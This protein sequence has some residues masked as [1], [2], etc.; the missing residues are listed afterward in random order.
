[1]ILT[2]LLACATDPQAAVCGAYEA[3]PA[4]PLILPFDWN[5]FS[6]P[7]APEGGGFVDA[8]LANAAWRAESDEGMQV[9]SYDASG[10]MIRSV[11]QWEGTDEDGQAHEQTSSNT[12]VWDATGC[13]S[14]L[15]STDAAGLESITR[16][17]CDQH[18][19]VDRMMYEDGSETE[20]VNSYNGVALATSTIGTTVYT[21]TYDRQGR[22]SGWG[23]PL[24]HRY[25]W[26]WHGDIVAELTHSEAYSEAEE[27]WNGVITSTWDHTSTGV[28]DG[29]VVEHTT[30]GG[31]EKRTLFEYAYDEL[32][33]I[34]AA[35]LGDDGSEVR[36]SVTCPG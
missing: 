5:L 33:S 15:R 16:Y 24:C 8:R 1:M 21:M 10:R 17:S 22:L 11:W 34:P 25:D 36:Y 29:K 20:I 27:G 31:T 18:G 13:P 14:E 7:V 26:I 32:F 19:L 35:L 28:A 12:V 23:D 9:K 2:L 4:A 30:L 6:V 3:P